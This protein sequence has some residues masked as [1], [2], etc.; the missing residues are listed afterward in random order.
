MRR[1]RR[2]QEMICLVDLWLL[3]PVELYW[4]SRQ[5]S[6]HAGIHLFNL[7]QIKSND[8]LSSIQQLPLTVVTN[9]CLKGIFELVSFQTATA[10]Q[11]TSL[12]LSLFQV[13][14]WPDHNHIELTYLALS[15]R[16]RSKISAV[17]AKNL[18]RFG[19]S[20]HS[21]LNSLGCLEII[22]KS[23]VWCC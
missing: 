19:L 17:S 15:K 20:C 3:L 13:C 7:L 4:G 22:I 6:T 14:I 16:L 11:Q 12:I 8:H 21:R 23:K 9:S 1:E 10:F 2:D 18:I 5:T